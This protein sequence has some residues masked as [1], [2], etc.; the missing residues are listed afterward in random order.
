MTIT[1]IEH[2]CLL[3]ETGGVNILTD[4]GT[5]SDAQNTLLGIHAIVITHEHGDHFHIEHVKEVMRKNPQAAVITN[6]S[7]GRLLAAQGIPHTVVDGRQSVTVNNVPIEAFDGKHEEIYEDFGQVQNTGYLIDNAFFL[8]GDSFVVVPDKPVRVLALPV[9]GPWCRVG[10]AI[11][12]AMRVKPA[13]AFPVHDGM[14]RPATTGFVTQVLGTI[15]GK[16]G[17]TYVGMGAADKKEF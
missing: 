5:Y 10:D 2:C 17:V 14:I 12:Y 3:I 1:K 13:K 16:A 8:P 7:V 9:A 15:L 6:A 11:R 4:P